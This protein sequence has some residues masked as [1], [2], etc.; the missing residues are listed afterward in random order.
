MKKNEQNEQINDSVSLEDSK[1][2]IIEI[3]DNLA[4]IESHSDLS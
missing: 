2:L 1:A 4:V 3:N